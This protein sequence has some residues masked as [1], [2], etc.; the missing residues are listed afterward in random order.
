MAPTCERG[1]QWRREVFILRHA[2]SMASWMSGWRACW[3]ACDW[4]LDE[5]GCQRYVCRGEC[6]DGYAYM[7]QM[8][9]GLAAMD[10]AVADAAVADERIV[11]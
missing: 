3:A 4:E 10:A 11:D 5:D 1:E 8:L 7:A 6:T 9:R 2:I